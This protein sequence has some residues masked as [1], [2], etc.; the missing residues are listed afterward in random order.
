MNAIDSA[1]SP[2]LVVACAAQLGEGPVW[3]ARDAALYWVDIKAPR[4]WRWQPASEQ[5]RN[6][7]PPCR[8]SAIA[9]R[10]RGGFVAA[11]DRGF[12]LIDLAAERY[13]FIGD[14][15]ADRPGNRFNDGKVDRQGCFWAGTM[16]DAE[17]AASGAL[18]RLD[19]GLNW[20]RFDEGYGVTN[21]PAFSADGAFLY[22]SDSV[23]REV[24]RFPVGASGRL[25][26]RAPFLRFGPE[27]GYP[28][29]MTTDADGCL[30]IAFWDGA[31]VRRFAPDGTP[32]ARIDLPVPRPT[33][34]AFGGE[35][36]DQLFITSA[37]TGLGEGEL[38]AWPLSGALFAVEPG[39]RG[40]EQP[41]FAG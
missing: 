16:D 7:E 6:W 14:P 13:D 29:G 33:S 39:V 3:V 15:E 23:K 34:C 19:A 12:A 27:H 20:E 2:R 37:W 1:L 11:T 26:A 4:I 36:L 41:L 24:Y 38:A 31:C 17:Q 8:V 32:L 22:H 40:S 5:V 9:P 30:W 18:Y 28:D 35:A 25:G 10:A 21:G